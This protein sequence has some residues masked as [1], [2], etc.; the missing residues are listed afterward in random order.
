M[1]K[2]TYYLGAGASYHA[3]PILDKQ[4]QMMIQLAR[5][6]LQKTGSYGEA[7]MPYEYKEEEVTGTD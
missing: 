4:A 5:M 2:I 3:Y 6:E 7:I 1:A